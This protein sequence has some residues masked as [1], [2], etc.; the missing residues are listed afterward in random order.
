[1]T[2][3]TLNIQRGTGSIPSGAC[4]TLQK[5]DIRDLSHVTNRLR[6]STELRVTLAQSVRIGHTSSI[7]GRNVSQNELDAKGMQF[8]SV[9]DLS[10]LIDGAGSD[11]G[12]AS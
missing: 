4:S 1:M 9:V 2:C 8:A 7:N 6:G 3:R 12:Q 5:T 10:P 11:R